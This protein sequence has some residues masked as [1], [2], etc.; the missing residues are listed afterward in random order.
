M[1]KA[2]YVISWTP[3]VAWVVLFTE[4]AFR[5]NGLFALGLVITGLWALPPE[6][7][8][9]KLVSEGTMKEVPELGDKTRLIILF[10]SL[11][12]VLFLIAGVITLAVL[13]KDL[14]ILAF[15][16]ILGMALYGVI[17]E[18]SREIRENGH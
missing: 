4:L 8:R 6:F 7:L 1:K 16:G 10:I 11:F 15:L 13:D 12:M 3:F 17:T 18:L 14:R 9:Q 2:F 5:V